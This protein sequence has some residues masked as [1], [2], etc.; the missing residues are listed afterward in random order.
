TL[1]LTV[2][3][4]AAL[5]VLV[6]TGGARLVR[7]LILSGLGEH[8]HLTAKSPAVRT[9]VRLIRA[10]LFLVTLVALLPPALELAGTP[11]RRGL[12]IEHVT[13]WAATGGL[14]LLLIALMAF[15]LIRVIRLLVRRFE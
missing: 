10:T 13:E 8:T 1:L 6:A 14:R 5:A 15:V 9:P 3:A 4:V 7:F 12:R 2:G 11:L